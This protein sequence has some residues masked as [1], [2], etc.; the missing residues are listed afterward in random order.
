[1]EQ[2]TVLE[3][4]INLRTKKSTPNAKNLYA[5][6]VDAKDL[7]IPKFVSNV[8]NDENADIIILTEFLKCNNWKEFILNLAHYNVFVNCDEN[9]K[10]ILI[11]VRK[12]IRVTKIKYNLDNYDERKAPHFL[13]VNL[14]YK[15]KEL[16]VVG[17]R[18]CVGNGKKEDYES[19]ANQFMLLKEHL[20]K[21][22]K[23]NI[24]AIG[25]FNNANIRDDYKGYLQE[26]YN[27][28]FIKKE[29][30]EINLDIHTP[31]NGF[32]HMGY[33]KEDHIFGSKNIEINCS[34]KDDFIDEKILGQ[35]IFYNIYYQG[36]YHQK[37]NDNNKKGIKIPS[38][39]PDHNILFAEIKL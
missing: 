3:W 12:D 30:E 10:G 7:I 18:I 8:L 15:G 39:Y 37:I 23:K 9:D 16:M 11:G 13:Q 33:L 5:Q 20:Y 35:D 34:Y 24:I 22:G 32:S 2:L 25:D 19:R 14:K 31:Q 6:P 1:M 17:T 26:S 38:G 28:S 36:N 29:F 4:N 21:L 27:Y